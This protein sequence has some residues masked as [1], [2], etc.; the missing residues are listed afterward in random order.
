MKTNAPTYYCIA[1]RF[2]GVAICGVF[3]SL[4]SFTLEMSKLYELFD[5]PSQIDTC[6]VRAISEK[7]AYEKAVEYFNAN[8]WNIKGL[9]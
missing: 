6:S 2:W 3:R 9:K 1:F 5:T 7:Q 4:E 8:G